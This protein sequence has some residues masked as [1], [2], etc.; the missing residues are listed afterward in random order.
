MAG[1]FLKSATRIEDLPIGAIPQVALLG[2]SNVGKS[3]LINHIAGEHK[4]ARTSAEPGRTRTMNVYEIDKQFRF[5]DLPGYGYARVSKE[6]REKLRAM[7]GSYLS[8]APHLALVLLITDGRHELTELDIDT[9]ESLQREHIP[10]VIVANKIDGVSR[11]EAGSRLA[12]L[13]RTYPNVQVI[14]HSARAGAGRG[15]ILEAIQGA[16][17]EAAVRHT[18]DK[19]E[20]G[21]RE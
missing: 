19:K 15:E 7:I 3:S 2:R 11:S 13:R 21:S 12:T 8:E 4:L 10:F 20:T 1:T 5:I 16:V 18:H 9:L 17:R 6:E 14:G